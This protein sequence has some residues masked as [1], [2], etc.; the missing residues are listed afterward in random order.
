M[1]NMCHQIKHMTAKPIDF[2]FGQIYCLTAPDGRK[3]IGQVKKYLVGGKIRGLKTRWF[4]HVNDA[5]LFQLGKK[6]KVAV[7]LCEAINLQGSD[8]FTREVILE[9]K[10]EYLN[11]FE[12]HFI[13]LYETTNPDKGFN[14]NA[15]H[16]GTT[17]RQKPDNF[18]DNLA[19]MIEGRRVTTYVE[20]TEDMLERVRNKLQYAVQI[21]PSLHRKSVESSN[22]PKHITFIK[23]PRGYNG[24]K[25]NIKNFQERNF[26]SGYS[27]SLDEALEN[28]LDYFA[29]CLQFT[30]N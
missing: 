22:L 26:R 6:T 15:G 5:R 2:D 21:Y 28:A 17:L 9:C 13:S 30:Y 4:Q 29:K 3:Y 24:Y 14:R 18:E 23:C 12:K 19:K 16:S 25:V 20:Y 11:E 10:L 8:N 7:P 1:V 27:N